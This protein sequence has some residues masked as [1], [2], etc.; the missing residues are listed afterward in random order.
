MSDIIYAMRKET[1][2][3][4]EEALRLE[5]EERHRKGLRRTLLFALALLA[6]GGIAFAYVARGAAF[7][8]AWALATP[9][10]APTPGTTSSPSPTREAVAPASPAPAE[11]ALFCPTAI[12]VDGALAGVVASREAAQAL[13]FDACAYF[14]R[15]A[16]GIG[17]PDTTLES[18]VEYRDATDGEAAA[19]STYEALFALLT[20]KDTPLTVVTTLTTESFADVPCETSSDTTKY[21]IKGT[22]LI[23]RMGRNGSV[24]SVTVARFVNGAPDGKPETVEAAAVEPVDAEILEGTQRVDPDAV[25]GRSEGQKGPDAGELTFIS[26]IE[27]GKISLNFGQ[28]EGVLHLGLDYKVEG[29]DAVRASC[30]GTVVC[31]MERGGYGLVIEIDHGNGFVTRYAHL[32]GA[33]VAPGQAVA[34][35]EEIGKAGS[36]GNCEG[37]VLHF[38][39]RIDGIAYN[40]RFYLD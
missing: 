20:G 2:H 36:S 4:P 14:E 18:E 21:L 3:I 39:L 30:T 25:P 22:R 7:V 33:S 28:H 16:E 34:Q 5:R 1:A 13:I 38:E 6:A 24:H 29:G 35:G 9:E 19:I 23:A 12:Y 8:P 27:G 40:P 37:P 11:T 15:K 17:V 26:P 10:P 31:V 32:Q